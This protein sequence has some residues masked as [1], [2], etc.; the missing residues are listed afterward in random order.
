MLNGRKVVVIIS[1][2][3]EVEDRGVPRGRPLN[4][5][6]AI[7]RAP[8][9]GVTRLCEMPPDDSAPEGGWSIEL[10]SRPKGE[11]QLT[12]ISWA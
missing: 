9:H 11:I 1:T 4:G 12:S 7:H 2:V 8:F 6:M 5:E 10:D 3:Y